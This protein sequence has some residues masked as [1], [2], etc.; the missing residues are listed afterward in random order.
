MFKLN[1]VLAA[2]AVALAMSATALAESKSNRERSDAPALEQFYP[3]AREAAKGLEESHTVYRPL[4]LRRFAPRS[5]PVIVWAN[6]ACR[7]SNL[8]FM[9]TLTTLANHGFVVIANGAHDAEVPFDSCSGP[10]I[11]GK[12][13]EPSDGD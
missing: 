11:Y 7:N 2:S 3:V 1:T 6:G 10:W 12:S 8:G 5:I 4:N 9:I 13:A